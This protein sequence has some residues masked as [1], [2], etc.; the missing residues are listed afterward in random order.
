MV[1]CTQTFLVA[2]KPQIIEPPIMRTTMFLLVITLKIVFVIGQVLQTLH[3]S[4][5]FGNVVVTV[6]MKNINSKIMIVAVCLLQ[7]CNCNRFHSE[8]DAQKIDT[9]GSFIQVDIAMDS[10]FSISDIAD[11]VMYFKLNRTSKSDYAFQ[12]FY[13]GEQIVL[14]DMNSLF[15][16]T[17]DGKEKN[18]VSCP[19]A[20][21]DY[22]ISNKRLHIY[23]FKKKSIRVF[24]S[25]GKLINTIRLKTSDG[26][27]FGHCFA[28]VDSSTYV[29]AKENANGNDGGL[30]F[31][32]STGNL[33]RRIGSHDSF[34]PVSSSYIYNTDWDYSIIRTDREIAYYPSYNDTIFWLKDGEK[35]EMKPFFAETILK[36]VPLEYRTEVSGTVLDDYIA[37]C[38]KNGWVTPRYFI[39]ERFVLAQYVH[40]R[41][42]ND[43]PGYL[44]YDKKSKRAIAFKNNLL[45]SPFHF[46]I[47][48]DYDGGLAF[49]PLNQCKNYLIMVGAGIAQGGMKNY[50]KKLYSIGRELCGKVYPVIS[51]IA[52]NQESKEKLSKFFSE[53]DEDKQTM[54]TILKLKK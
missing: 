12:V 41:F 28:S 26:G 43:L 48:N 23:E 34:L 42:V 7:S 19:F 38:Y 20:C 22:D 45:E 9:L 13:D 49:T 6:S 44:L 30:L 2:L 54:I 51:G 17:L 4:S 32:S 25:D 10:V 14:Y 27:T 15:F 11:T 5:V 33:I 8:D 40:G 1:V 47:Y 29:L 39:N 53:F 21:V 24:T 52:K 35:G 31:I 16:Y 36:K 50:P 3:Q 18:K 37:Q 46:G